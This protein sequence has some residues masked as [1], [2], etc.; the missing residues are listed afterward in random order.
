MAERTMPDNVQSAFDILSRDT[1]NLHGAW[2]TFAAL[3][4]RNS[5]RSKLLA[6]TANTF[7]QHLRVMILTDVILGISRLLDRPEMCGR[8]NLVLETLS[9]AVSDTSI[10]AELVDRI[11]SLRQLAD[12]IIK[13]RHRKF[14]HRD[15]LVATSASGEAL[16]GITGN[17]VRDVLKGISDFLNAIEQYYLG[18]QCGYEHTVVIGGADDLVWALRKSATFD[19]LV[20]EGLIDNSR[21]LTG[22]FKDA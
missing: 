19:E 9:N 4:M 12:P 3:Y 13:T 7:F 6:R 2:K 1:T 16:P 18:G 20:S 14:S 17:L 8:E 10:H 5:P 21:L 22:D 11:A 15:R